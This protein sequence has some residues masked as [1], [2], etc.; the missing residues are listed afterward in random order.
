M[1]HLSFSPSLGHASFLG[2]CG[3]DPVFR[4]VGVGGEGRGVSLPLEA[5][6]N[7]PPVGAVPA[8]KASVC[9]RASQSPE[10]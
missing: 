6:G 8:L 5:H 4:E 2:F 3:Q 10:T 7:H 1:G 9:P